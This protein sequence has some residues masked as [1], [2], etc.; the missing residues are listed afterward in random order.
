MKIIVAS[1]N[2]VK[3]DAVADAFSQFY[4]G[5]DCE[6]TGI[7]APSGVKP[8]PMTN[9]ET[10]QGAF[11]RINAART[12]Q[13]HADFWVGVEGGLHPSG[14]TYEVFAWVAVTDGAHTSTAR[15]GTFHLPPPLADLIRQG[16]ELGDADDLIFGRNNSKQE[17]GA[18]G[19]LT[20]DLI[21]RQTYYTPAVIMALIPFKNPDL[22]FV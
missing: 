4:P 13:P 5:V 7:P 1:A 15:T 20:G 8:Q 21:T 9:E 3:V 18:I 10:L 12:V 19:I 17:N 22:Y 2:P 6:V 11:N 16:L 14:V